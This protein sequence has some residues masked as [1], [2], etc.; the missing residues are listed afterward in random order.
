MRSILTLRFQYSLRY[1]TS[2]RGENVQVENPNN[3]NRNFSL[4]H[5]HCLIEVTCLRF[6]DYTQS[7]PPSGSVND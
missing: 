6:G 7:R 1:Y 2:V 5:S 4:C 3:H